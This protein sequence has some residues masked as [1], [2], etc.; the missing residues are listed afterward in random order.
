MRQRHSRRSMLHAVTAGLA[1]G[2]LLLIVGPAEAQPGA[3]A[4]PRR[5]NGRPY[6]GVR[7]LDA[8]PRADPEGYGRGPSNCLDRDPIDPANIARCP[9][10]PH[11]R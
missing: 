5:R 10:K 4:R 2:A 9:R 11:R 7:D 6:T 8:G 3:A 1:G